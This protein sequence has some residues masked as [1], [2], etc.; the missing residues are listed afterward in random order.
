MSIINFNIITALIAFILLLYVSIATAQSSTGAATQPGGA[1]AQPGGATVQP[2]AAANSSGGATV[3]PTAAANSSGGA[4]GV[5][6]VTKYGAK[7]NADI[8]QVKIK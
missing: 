8:T 1:A 5:F 2:T 6:D 3:Q 7:P 4:G